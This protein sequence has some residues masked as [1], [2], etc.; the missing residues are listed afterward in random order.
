MYEGKEE[1]MGK[2]CGHHPFIHPHPRAELLLGGF[3][4]YRRHVMSTFPYNNDVHGNK[5]KHDDRQAGER[6]GRGCEAR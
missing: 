3:R 5:H 1:E 2:I 6:K 4:R